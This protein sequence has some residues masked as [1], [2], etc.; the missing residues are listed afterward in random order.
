MVESESWT[1]TRGNI[2]GKKREVRKK[3]GERTQASTFLG[4]KGK[5][6]GGRKKGGEKGT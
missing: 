2:G 3:G 1:A 5:N 6:R 4:G